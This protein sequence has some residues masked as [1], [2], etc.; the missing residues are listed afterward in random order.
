[1]A[2]TESSNPAAK[3]LGELLKQQQDPFVLEIYLSERGCLRKKMKK[4]KKKGIPNFP[5]LLKVVLCDKLFAIKGLKT[6]NCDYENG[7]VGV[8]EMKRNEQ[9]TAAPDRVYNPC[10]DSVINKAVADSKLQWS[11]PEDS[12]EDGPAR[13]KSLFLSKLI[14]EDSILSASLWNFLLQTTPDKPSWVRERETQEECLG[15]EG[16]CG[17]MK[18]GDGL[19]DNMKLPESDV[20]GWTS[21]REPNDYEEQKKDVGVVVGNAIA[22]EIINE[23]VKDMIFM[24]HN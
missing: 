7:K 14:M 1:M 22:E 21:T 16:V 24:F 11:S 3:Q 23:V 9:E 18:Y 20:M 13:Q 19:S 5:K 10:T 4:K 6:K 17:K 12:K 15:S 8:T 2:V